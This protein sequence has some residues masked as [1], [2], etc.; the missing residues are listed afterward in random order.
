M[1]LRASLTKLETELVVK[2]RPNMPLLRELAVLRELL[3]LVLVV[4]TPPLPPEALWRATAAKVS[5]KDTADDSAF[6][7][8]RFGA[9][10]RSAGEEESAGSLKLGTLKLLTLVS[11]VSIT[12]VLDCNSWTH[13]QNILG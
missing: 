8:E 5:S 3:A 10:Q 13:K 6:E 9:E 7:D 2:P 1:L 4:L 11:L 12:R